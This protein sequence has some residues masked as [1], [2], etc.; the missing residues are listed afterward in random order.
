MCVRGKSQT[1]IHE[2][3]FGTIHGT[4]NNLLQEARGFW[5]SYKIVG[6][7]NLLSCFMSTLK[8]IL[9]VLLILLLQPK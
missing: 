7:K 4:V 9:Q 8:Y 2:E 1:T 5:L 3:Y 6:Y